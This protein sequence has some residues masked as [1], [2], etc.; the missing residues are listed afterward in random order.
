MYKFRLHLSFK[1]NFWSLKCCPRV[2]SDY[3]RDFSEHMKLCM[4][5]E[6]KG[7]SP[8]DIDLK[9]LFQLDSK[10][11]ITPRAFFRRRDLVSFINDN[12]ML[13]FC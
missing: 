9:L 13:N 10:K 12:L 5:Y 3:F 7:Q 4:R 6:G 1:S 2:T 8:P 11:T